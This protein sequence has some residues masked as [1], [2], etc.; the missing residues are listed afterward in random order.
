LRG[1]DIL[2]PITNWDSSAA[3]HILSRT[4]FGF[5]QKDIEFALSFTLNDFVDNYLLKS[6][7]IPAIPGEWVNEIPVP[8][9]T[10]ID[11][12]RYR[13]LCRWWL[14]LMTNQGISIQERLVLFLHNHFVSE[15][16][17]V[18]FP[19]H[20]YW[21]NYL[22]R[23]FSLGN[24]KQLTKSITINPAMLLYL[25]GVQNT[26]TKPNENY[27]RE[28]LELFTIGIG[29]YT[30][31]DV[32]EAARALT[33]WRVSGL[34]AYF[35][36]SRFD[37][38]T[39]TFLGHTGNFNHEDIVNIIFS[40]TETSK[41]LCR[42]LY[43]EFVFYQPDEIYVS[44]LAQV[45]RD[46]NFVLKPVLS[47]MLKSTYFHSNEIRGAK[48]KSPVELL[49]NSIR[50]FLILNPDFD[51]M[52]TTANSLQQVLFSPPDVRG[53]ESQRKWISTTTYP[54]R[55]SYTDSIVDGKKSS[56]GNLSFK[57]NTINFARTFP[58]SENAVQFV[59]DV[60]D[61]L[62][63]FPLSQSRKN[64]LLEI[65]L[66]GTAPENWSTYI[67]QA[68]ARLKAFFKALMRLPE[69]QLC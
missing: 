14:G 65:M 64:Y 63:R 18:R 22:F 15:I 58:S 34:D 39:K 61:Y 50:Q 55:N 52:R 2:N 11:S 6:Q 56:G 19:Q 47:T 17:V 5:T 36:S 40:K 20:M 8:N 21:Q 54:M 16:E 7:P 23:E 33:G 57:I 29:N 69:Y 31:F 60:T 45:I 26:K 4:T 10:N 46:N 1:K 3:K 68:E 24:F 43:K 13:E 67:P 48:I 49:I 62:F 27:A 41:F 66:D 25:D 53:W 28:L 37:N 9:N 44:Q 12:Q 32:R 30:E 42:K 51:Y 59:N 38:G 35:T